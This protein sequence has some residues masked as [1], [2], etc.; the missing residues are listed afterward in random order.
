[1]KVATSV[2]INDL[3]AASYIDDDD[4]FIVEQN[5]KAKKLECS[6][7]K[8]YIDRNIVSIETFQLEFGAKLTATY[9]PLSGK[10]LLG[11]PKANSVESIDMNSDGY[12]V[13]TFTNGEST[14]LERIKGD[15][16]KT[17]YQYAVEY[18]YQGTEEEWVIAQEKARMD[19]ENS[20]NKAEKYKKE[21]LDAKNNAYIYC[22]NTLN[23]LKQTEQNA[24]DA[25]NA[26]S[27]A[28]N[29]EHN[30]KE[31]EK[32]AA[33]SA[34][35]A[36]GSADAAAGSASSAAGSSA[37]AGQSANAAAGSASAALES[38][39]AA[40]GSAQEAMQSKNAAANSADSAAGS[41]SAAAGSASAAAGSAEEALESK[42]AAAGSA[43]AAQEALEKTQEIS[44]NPAY[45][46]DNGNWFV[47]DTT[48]DRYVDSGVKAQGPKGDPG[49]VQ[50]V[51]GVAPDASGNV[52]LTMAAM[53]SL[54][55]SK[56]SVVLPAASWADGQQTVAI[57][58]LTA[59]GARTDIVCTPASADRQ[60][61]SRC[62]VYLAEQ[63]DGAARFACGSVPD[64]DITVDILLFTGVG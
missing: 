21:A 4:V 48:Q 49:A 52:T 22:E 53:G 26:L 18:G 64:G 13:Y 24:I 14:V 20:A 37:S 16:G 60:R 7:F 55:V 11:I 32:N 27:N 17:A 2:P 59:D 45:I 41:A 51:C 43:Q 46:G 54:A 63:L 19:S 56:L 61:Y 15:T 9:D 39:N 57:A 12:I 62:G 1:M 30:S 31:S 25:E 8:Q 40:A 33:A 3:S 34:S 10:L 42:N 38:K 35:S 58:G 29:S 47:W 44:V 36:A 28:R 6:I 23:Y 50:T 5:G